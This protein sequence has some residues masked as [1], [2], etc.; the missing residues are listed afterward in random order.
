MTDQQT[1]A[2]PDP[3]G[4]P[5]PPKAETPQT[6]AQAMTETMVNAG[7]VPSQFKD[8]NG[9]VNQTHLFQTLLAMEKGETPA[10]LASLASDAE[11]NTAPTATAAP[12][13]EKPSEAESLSDALTGKPLAE[14]ENPWA[15]ASEQLRTKGTVDE[16]VVKALKDQG[17]TDEALAAMAHGFKAKQ[18]SDMDTSYEVCGGKEGFDATIAWAKANLS[19]DEIANIDSGFKTEHAALVLGG[20]HARAQAAGPQPSGQVDTSTGEIAIASPGQIQPFA[21]KQEA[22]AAQRSKEYITDPAFRRETEARIMLMSGAS[23]EQ[24]RAAGLL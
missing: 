2:A 7:T 3:T 14:G 1:T 23:P 21:T 11:T 9:N 20:L 18:K 10:A 15:M 17:A 22:M 16:N 5:T 6:R 19:P 13:P 4:A 24:L 8:E 12:S